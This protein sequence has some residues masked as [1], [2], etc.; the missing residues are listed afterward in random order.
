M[1]DQSAYMVHKIFIRKQRC[2][3]RA[4]H[5]NID[6]WVIVLKTMLPTSRFKRT[7]CENGSSFIYLFVLF[8]QLISSMNFE[9]LSSLIM[10]IFFYKITHNLDKKMQYESNLCFSTKLNRSFKDSLKLIRNKDELVL[11]WTVGTWCSYLWHWHIL[12]MA[13]IRVNVLLHWIWSK[14]GLT[15]LVW[16]IKLTR[17]V[18]FRH[19]TNLMVV[20]K[21]QTFLSF[22]CSFCL[23]KD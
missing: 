16:R 20:G 4:K 3:A 12:G 6:Y 5:P 18:M 2:F 10:W 11:E 17:A 9:V 14:T 21:E 1:L 13:R 19:T 22:A 8:L 7:I 15:R 23:G